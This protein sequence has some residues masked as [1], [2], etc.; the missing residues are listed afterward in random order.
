MIWFFILILTYVDSEII[1]LFYRLLSTIYLSLSFRSSKDTFFVFL[2]FLSFSITF[3]ISCF[4]QVN[5][6]FLL[7]VIVG[8]RLAGWSFAGMI[9]FLCERLIPRYVFQTQRF[10]LVFSSPSSRFRFQM[11][12]RWP[13]AHTSWGNL[14]YQ[15]TIFLWLWYL[16]SRN[17]I[18][19]W[20]YQDVIL[21]PNLYC[22]VDRLVWS[23]LPSVER[24]LSARLRH[25]VELHFLLNCRFSAIS[26]IFQLF[27][28]RF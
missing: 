28:V 9:V 22:W 15:S 6:S 27:F 25:W 21:A 18:S 14:S 1:L 3:A 24:F 17:S 26:L 12:C 5:I 23:Y 2:L 4:L 20:I 10:P 11:N 8:C 19:S 7:L 16:S 13:I